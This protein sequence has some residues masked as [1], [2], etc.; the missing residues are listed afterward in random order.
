MLEVDRAIGDRWLVTKGLAAG[1]RSS[2]TT[3]RRSARAIREGRPFAPRWAPRRRRL[4]LA[5]AARK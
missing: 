1:T 2:S 4:C 5:E 3:S